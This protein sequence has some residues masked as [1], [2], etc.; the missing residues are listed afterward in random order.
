MKNRWASRSVCIGILIAAFF[1]VAACARYQQKPLPFRLP[2][3]YPNAVEAFGATIAAEAWD[4]PA[5]AKEAFGFDILKAGI[6]PVQVIFDHQGTAP[7][8]IVPSQSFLFDAQG[9]LWNIL[10]QKM[11]Y[12]RIEKAT[13]W[14]EVAPGAGKG[15]LLGAAGGAIVGAAIGIVT[16]GNVGEAIGKGA[17]VGGAGGAVVGGAKGLEDSD[18]ERSIRDDLRN[19]SLENKPIPPQSLSHGVLFFPSEAQ[20]AKQLRIQVKDT[21]SGEAR[22]FSLAL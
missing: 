18:V 3:A 6:L 5:K 14:G 22:V 10:D 2:G 15:A 8:E 9:Q 12:A 4:D 17:A 13:D 21:G 11:A 7:I 1:A 16:G 20:G 19:R